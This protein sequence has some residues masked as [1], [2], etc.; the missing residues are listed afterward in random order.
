VPDPLVRGL[1]PCFA[2]GVTGPL[3]QL[4]DEFEYETSTGPGVQAKGSAPLFARPSTPYG[5]HVEPPN[6][7]P[8]PYHSGIRNN[9]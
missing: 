6:G 4:H 3:R 1:W 2:K 7:I 5:S 8:H 9:R